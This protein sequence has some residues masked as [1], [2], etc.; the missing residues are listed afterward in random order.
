[1]LTCTTISL[2]N[3]HVRLLSCCLRQIRE[4]CGDLYPSSHERSVILRAIEALCGPPIS[5]NSIGHWD[6]WT[7]EGKRHKGS[8]VSDIEK[9]RLKP[10]SFNLEFPFVDYS[11]VRPAREHRVLLPFATSVLPQDS[12]SNHEAVTAENECTPPPDR[13]IAVET[14]PET[15]ST[16]PS[17][18]DPLLGQMT[19]E[20]L[21]SMVSSKETAVQEMA[22]KELKE[23]ERK[24]EEERKKKEDRAA[25]RQLGKTNKKQKTGPNTDK[26]NLATNNTNGESEGVC[27]PR[28]FQ[29]SLVLF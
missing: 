29:A 24:K 10:H 20:E 7:S 26:E 8:A 2:L 25:I 5:L 19:W 3:K 18:K 23:K 21:K 12:P 16:S 1:M 28:W 6:N 15:P 4:V 11:G 13:P 17:T 27:L 22:E 9:A 14:A